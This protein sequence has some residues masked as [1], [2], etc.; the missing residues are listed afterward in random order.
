M[1]TNFEIAFRRILGYVPLW[2]S[3]ILTSLPKKDLQRLRKYTS[4]ARNIAK[5]LVRKELDAHA[6]G[7]EGGRD[8]MSLF[9]ERD[10]LIQCKII[11]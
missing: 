3:D 4:A 5:G 9:G 8:V 7:K 2:V 10:S 11:S 6:N 1:P